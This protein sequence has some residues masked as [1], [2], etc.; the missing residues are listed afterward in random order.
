M[1][2][3]DIKKIGCWNV[4]SLIDRESSECPERRSA[5]IATEL[6]RL[7]IDVAALSETRLA[8]QGSFD[9]TIGNDG[10][11]FYWS[12]K[13]VGVKRES[14]VGFAIRKHIVSKLS[15]LPIALNDRMMTLRLPL[16]KDKFVTFVSV[17]APTL[18]SD[19]AIKNNFYDQ[20]HNLLVKI[21][22]DDKLI[23]MGDFNARV[24]CDYESWPGIIGRH[25][26][27]KENANGRLLLEL[28]SIH[29]LCITN[30]KFQ[31]PDKL[32]VTWKHPR[33]H[34]WHQLDHI[35]TRRKDVQDI[36]LTRV[37][38]SAECWTDHR[39]LKSNVNFR[40]VSKKRFTKYSM[41]KFDINRLNDP[42]IV[43]C[44]ENQ[45]KEELEL[46][47]EIEGSWNRLKTAATTAANKTIG[48][49]K[50]KR[51]DWFDNNNDEI[52]DL[53][54]KK[55]AA[56]AKLQQNPRSIELN[57]VFQELKRETQRTLRQLRDQWWEA[58]ANH[59]QNL[60]DNND[61]RFYGEL[62]KIIGPTYMCSTPLRHEDGQ[63]LTSK[64]EILDRWKRHFASLLNR[65]TTIA[66]SF[67]DALPQ[68]PLHQDMEEIPTHDEIDCA[69]K[70]LKLGKA[71]GPDGLAAEFYQRGGDVFF[72]E[73][74]KVIH[75]IWDT[76]E[77]PQ[78]IKNATIVTIFK[79]KGDKTDCGNWRGISLLS[80]AGKV[81]SRILLNRLVDAIAEE[82]LPESQCGFRRGRGTTDMVFTLRQIQEKSREQQKPLYMVFIDLT[83]AF[84][85]VNRDA[86]WKVLQK[87]GCPPKFVSLVKQL[88][89][90]M[91][92][93]IVS[94]GEKSETFHVQTGVKQGC[95]L[96]P[97]LFALFLAA[98]L[99]EMNRMVDQQG[100]FVEHRIDGRL[101]NLRR[102]MAKSKTTT[103]TLR[104]LLFADDC[105]LVAHSVN[106]MQELVHA[107]EDAASS[108]GLQINVKKTEY[109]FQPAPGTTN[110][111]ENIY[112]N[113]EALKKVSSF[114]YLGSVISDD[115]TVDRDITVRLQK[116]SKAYGALQKKLWSQRGIQVKTKLKVYKA[117]VI[118]TLLYGS[119]SWPLYRRNV[120][121]LEKFH[122]RCLRRILRIHWTERVTNAEVLKRAELTG[123]ECML[124]KQQLKW[125]G[126][127]VRMDD[128]RFPKQVFY[129]QLPNAPRKAGGQKLRYK[130]TVRH[131]LQ[132][133]DIRQ[134]N[135]EVL[136]SERVVWKGKINSGLKSFEEKRVNKMIEKNQLRHN[137]LSGITAT[138]YICSKC[139]RDCRSRI[140][141]LSHERAHKRRKDNS[142]S[143]K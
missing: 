132:R 96:A 7:G 74:V 44:F 70:S 53:L 30:T 42:N 98:M 17:Y 45:L 85:S 34:R 26:V 80:I 103:T 122:L 33:S 92:A 79:R 55:H 28:S 56:L 112:I 140:G 118:S 139:Q 90:G 8:E 120:Q 116:A 143:D 60:A 131:N 15:D 6:L 38:R 100:V 66:P 108:F 27:G 93:E 62:K 134:D 125:V 115:C 82:I 12:G 142:L 126:H 3:V 109:M 111:A 86:L 36:Q 95:V 41:R 5:L 25:G 51:E 102:L 10:Y 71:A 31:L 46:S 94:E 123:I 18:T 65:D 138:E 81:I 76:E 1:M 14:G 67:L 124:I 16:V 83:K 107:F 40:V 23:L 2:T 11:R 39:L 119:Q 78:E 113:G 50:N 21:S 129:G 37:L 52:Q 49:K 59:L 117:A 130:D 121:E 61:K 99:T 73:V 32:K 91:T 101:Y 105:A 84:D 133:V 89:E 13:S 35:I 48:L 141:L 114:S 20:L 68:Q 137:L 88:H 9:E 87:M 75:C 106:D 72:E 69:I 63:L 77:I 19:D 104:D 57:R 54:E 58:R 136:A 127:V 97:T 135:W 29:Q 24:G 110:I 128:R 47:K 64:T 22:P 4:R 43:T